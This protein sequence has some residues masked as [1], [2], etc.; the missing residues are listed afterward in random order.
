[1]VSAEITTPKVTT[2]NGYPF[3]QIDVTNY[4]MSI[5]YAVICMSIWHLTPLIYHVNV[6]VCLCYT[7]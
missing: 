3:Q 5:I 7:N 6:L 4:F 1:M 2:A